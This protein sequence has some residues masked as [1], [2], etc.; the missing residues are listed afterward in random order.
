M[1]I[2][3]MQQ[4]E[5]ELSSSHKRRYSNSSAN[6]KSNRSNSEIKSSVDGIHSKWINDE[7]DQEERK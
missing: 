6:W 7:Y 2:R 4:V 5:T 1:G 3:P